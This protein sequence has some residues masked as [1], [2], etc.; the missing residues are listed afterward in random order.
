MNGIM[1]ER[2]LLSLVKKF[3]SLLKMMVRDDGKAGVCFN[4]PEHNVPPLEWILKNEYDYIYEALM[5][6]RVFSV[7]DYTP[8][9]FKEIVFEQK[10]VGFSCYDIGGDGEFYILKYIYV[11]PEYRGN[12]LLVADLTDTA[13]SF[14]DVGLKM[15]GVHMPN[16]FVMKSLVKRGLAVE[17]NNHLIVSHIPLC[18]DIGSKEELT[19]L[20]LEYL[21]SVNF[22]IDEM[23]SSMVI[24]FLYDTDLCATVSP[25]FKLISG[26]CDVDLRFDSELL[27][28]RMVDPNYY[29]SELAKEV[30][31]AMA[32]IHQE[33][34]ME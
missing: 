29:F 34:D 33:D 9:L 1:V 6:E 23:E 32:N 2:V 14:S 7:T 19:G 25:D 17:I 11:L 13:K 15:I 8:T 30:E 10:V 12:N 5:E 31:N 24:T 18:I 21:M 26:I 27:Q 16:R 4:T 28:R 22:D 20:E 3:R